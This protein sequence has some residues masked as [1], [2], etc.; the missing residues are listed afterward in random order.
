METILSV[1]NLCKEYPGFE[2]DNISFEIQ[3]GQIMGLIGRNGAGKSTTIKSI[4]NLIHSTGQIRYFGM[5]L[6]ENEAYIKQRIGYACGEVNYYNKKKISSIVNVTRKFYNSWDES[7]YE[8]YLKLFDLNESKTPGELSS[9]MKV[10][11][12]LALALSHGARLLILDEPTSGLDPV[13]RDELLEI[14]KYLA[15]EG[16]AILFSTHITSD[17]DKCADTITYIRNGHLEYTGRIVD[18]VQS[19]SEQ[20]LGCNLEEIMI[21]FEREALHEQFAL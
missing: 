5:N 17:L 13:S 8:R 19:C 14:F 1:K 10:K 4:L 11:L 9:G 2:L 6:L 3:E 21:H 7:A 20:G 16:T 15:G 12:N 18:Y